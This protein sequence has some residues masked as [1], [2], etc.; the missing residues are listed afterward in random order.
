ME[1]NPKKSKA[2]IITFILIL[3]LLMVGYYLFTNRNKIF[4]TKGSTSISKIFAPLL[5]GSKDKGLAVI[6][7]N[8]TDTSTNAPTTA[9]VATDTTGNKIVRAEAG[10]DLKKCDA[11][12]VS[13]FNKNKD[14]IVMKAIANDPKKSVVFGF[15]GEDIKKGASGNIVI[16]GILNV[17][18]TQRTEGTPWSTNNQL[19]LSSTKTGDMTKN[20]PSGAGSIVVPLASILKVDPVVG[21]INI[22]MV[23]YL[24]NI[25]NLDKNIS[26]YLK[27]LQQLILGINTNNLNTPGGDFSYIPVEIPGYNNTGNNYPT[28]TV[29]AAKSSINEGESTT[30]SW[31][32]KKATSCNAGK[33]NGTG[34]SGS[35]NTGPLTKTTA[36]AVSCTGPGGSNGGNTFVIV[37]NTDGQTN[38]PNITIQATPKDIKSGESSL[39][40]WSSENTV[41]CALSGGG[42][43]GTGIKNDKG[44]STG[45]LKESMIYMIKCIGKNKMERAEPVF[46]MVDDGSGDISNFPT[47]KLT[48]TPKMVEEGETSTLTWTSENAV[49]C[50]LSGGDITSTDLNNTK[51]IK[52]KP[53]TQSMMYTV[54]CTGKNKSVIPS[55]EF[56]V[57]NPD[58][59][60][61]SVTVTAVKNPIDYDTKAT[62][63]WESKNTTSCN[64]GTGNGTGV[65]G[66]F[67]TASLKADKSFTVS[68]IGPSGVANGSININV[69]ED[70]SGTNPDDNTSGKPQCSDGVDNDGDKDIDIADSNCHEGGDITKPYVPDHDS[71]SVPA[72]LKDTAP[73]VNS[74]SLIEKNPLVFT[75]EE[76]A[77]LDVL[78]RKFYL[79]S[80][81]LRTEEDIATIYNEIEQQKNFIKQTSL[82]TK[83][84][85]MQTNDETDYKDFCSRNKG[86]CTTGEFAAN[87]NTSYDTSSIV[88]HGNPW[89]TV[90][91]GGTYPYTKDN[92]GYLKPELLKE[93]DVC[94]A[95][96]GYYYGMVLD[97]S[98]GLTY[99]CST[100]NS[101]LAGFENC[102]RST[103]DPTIISMGC[104]WVDG[105]D[106]KDTERILN[107]W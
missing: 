19:Y 79:I 45:P 8:K 25:N 64:A 72:P 41:S 74:C 44:V 104:K 38:F 95:Q 13:G 53:L 65:K 82:L 4:D 5:G 18:N 47:V 50:K 91:S 94:Q 71:E 52:T 31:T 11:V 24:K 33:G 30:I 69:N 107:I 17:C 54:A 3:L 7:E 39:I 75:E 12:Y 66:T 27:S 55:S 46:V 35:F 15:A 1:N 78:L 73:V 98:D 92:S 68:C 96:S 22:F 59:K 76:K 83:Q 63:K 62:I 23:D 105:V 100:Y 2:F 42:I 103:P 86:L 90:Q 61:P 40:T 97:D 26:D 48:A 93:A 6:D 43:T 16:Q 32:S 9:M 58:P 20:P 88:R 99:N 34:A 77:R 81:T 60:L 87:A 14:P 21:S 80:S 37:A 36:Y 57:V 102:T 28:V 10:E 56:V 85:Y 84:C 51:G 29:T 106:F 70:T 67:Q 89:F 101:T 49:S